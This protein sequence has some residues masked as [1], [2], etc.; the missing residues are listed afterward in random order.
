[1]LADIITTQ[2][3]YCNVLALALCHNKDVTIFG[4]LTPVHSKNGMHKSIYK[5]FKNF[6]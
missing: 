5:T 4:K 6:T 1:M 3:K 2:Y